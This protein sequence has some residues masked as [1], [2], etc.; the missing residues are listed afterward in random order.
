MSKV[1][2]S[3]YY[4]QTLHDIKEIRRLAVARLIKHGV[5]IG[6]TLEC[7]LEAHYVS[8]PGILKTLLPEI[9]AT[10]P[11]E[12]WAREKDEYREMEKDLVRISR[13]EFARELTGR[14]A[15]VP[16]Y[17]CISYQH[18]YV[19]RGTLVYVVHMRGMDTRKFI[20]DL[21]YM[22]HAANSVVA[23]GCGEI[24]YI[25]LHLLVDCFHTYTQEVPL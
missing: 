3:L 22:L 14:R 7:N 18:C 5:E 17:G 20:G 9:R 15:V 1:D 24:S 23:K 25:H 6:N 13:R 2:D 19:R 8:T 12:V 10:I 4:I 11:P 16:C 21:Y